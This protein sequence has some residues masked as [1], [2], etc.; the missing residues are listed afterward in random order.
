MVPLTTEP[1]SS[2][3]QTLSRLY[4]VNIWRVS[5]M[6]FLY[7]PARHFNSLFCF[8]AGMFNVATSIAIPTTRCKRYVSW[9][10]ILN[11]I[12]LYR[13]YTF[14]YA[15]GEILYRKRTRYKERNSCG[16]NEMLYPNFSSLNIVQG[17]GWHVNKLLVI[18]QK[19]T[20]KFSL[21]I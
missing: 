15:I 21:I 18:R 7:M 9:I 12:A 3:V 2:C 13:S 20:R 1:N 6:Q 14:V 5:I 8:L 11:Q 16:S 10:H 19:Y 4:F 17:S